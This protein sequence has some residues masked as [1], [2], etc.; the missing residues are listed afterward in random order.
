[1]ALETATYVNQL[2]QANPSGADYVREG[3]DHIRLI[4]R[5]LKSTF[6]NISGPVTVSQDQL[7]SVFGSVVPFG[8]MK[9]SMRV[10]VRLQPVLRH[11]VFF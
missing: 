9:S 8:G 10:P 4:K 5:V 1:M 11:S 2:V 6:P 7:N 3:D